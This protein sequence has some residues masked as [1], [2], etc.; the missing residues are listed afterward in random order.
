MMK[1]KMVY[2][3]AWGNTAARGRSGR[4]IGYVNSDTN[5]RIRGGGKNFEE[6]GQSMGDGEDI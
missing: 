4:T 1:K 2:M 5:L 6:E 3:M